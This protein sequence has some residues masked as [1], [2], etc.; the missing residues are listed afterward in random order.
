[1]EHGICISIRNRSVAAQLNRLFVFWVFV[2]IAWKK[3]DA[4]R[5]RATYLMHIQMRKSVHNHFILEN[6]WFGIGRTLTQMDVVM[7]VAAK[8][9]PRPSGLLRLESNFDS[10]VE[11]RTAMCNQSSSVQRSGNCGWCTQWCETITNA[12]AMPPHAPPRR[13]CS[14]VEQWIQT[15]IWIYTI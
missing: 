12:F 3:N 14:V 15:I 5:P 2:R 9:P 11:L 7:S 10:D 4:I 1:M 8:Q 6:V 13:R